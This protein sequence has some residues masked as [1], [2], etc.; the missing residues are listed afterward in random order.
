MGWFN[1]EGSPLGDRLSMRC[2]DKLLELGILEEIDNEVFIQTKEFEKIVKWCLDGGISLQNS[3]AY[4]LGRHSIEY[5]KLEE[6]D[7]FCPNVDE[8][9]FI[10]SVLSKPH[11]KEENKDAI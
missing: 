3:I 8:M 1:L 6:D 10:I 5:S 11:Q 2:L 9:S 7:V 4:A